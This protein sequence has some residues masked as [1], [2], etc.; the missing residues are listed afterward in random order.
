MREESDDDDDD[1]TNGFDNFDNSDKFDENLQ[2]QQLVQRYD[3]LY[4]A[5]IHS[6]HQIAYAKRTLS[7]ADTFPTLRQ[8][9]N[10]YCHGM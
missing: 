6:S 4:I 7:S 10:G 3:E 9:L 8:L 2:A 5:G 1:D